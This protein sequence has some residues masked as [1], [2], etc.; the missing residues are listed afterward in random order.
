MLRDISLLSGGID[1]FCWLLCLFVSWLAL[2]FLDVVDNRL[3]FSH[4]F[5]D[6]IRCRSRFFRFGSLFCLLCL[7][8]SKQFGFHAALADLAWVVECATAL[9]ESRNCLFGCL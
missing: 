2:S 1:Y 3:S 4:G 9:G 8:V 7:L 6:G 5:A